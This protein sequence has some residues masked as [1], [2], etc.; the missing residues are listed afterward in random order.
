MTSTDA[1]R[2]RYVVVDLVC[3]AGGASAGAQIAIKDLDGEMEL[4]AVNH[5]PVAVAT[6]RRN[7]PQARHYVRDLEGVCLERKLGMSS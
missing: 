3:G 5:W 1:P 2:R 4:A 6:H 7:H